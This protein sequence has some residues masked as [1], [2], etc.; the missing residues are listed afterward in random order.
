MTYDLKVQHEALIEIQ[1]AYE[2]YEKKRVGLGDELIEELEDCYQ[3]ISLNPQHYSFADN[4]K[5]FRRIKVARFPYIIIYEVEEDRVIIISVRN[6]WM[7]S[8]Y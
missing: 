7:K 5:E 3:K 1:E 2:W 8:R 4:R 6:T